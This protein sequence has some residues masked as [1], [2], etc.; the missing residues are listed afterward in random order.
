MTTEDEDN[1]QWNWVQQAIE[2]HQSTLIRYAANL[3]GDSERA[4]DVVQDTFIKLCKKTAEEIDDHLLPWLFRVTRNHALNVLRKENRM[5]QLEDADISQ[6]DAAQIHFKDQRK[7]ETISS[8]FEL[9]DTLP[10]KQRELVLLK[11]QQDFS[12]QQ[13]AEITGLTVSNVGYILHNAIRSLKQQWASLEQ[14]A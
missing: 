3:L 10:T 14:R 6:K 11:F 2:E 1:P 5:S 12:Y 8:L 7:K 13:I 9:V 4:K